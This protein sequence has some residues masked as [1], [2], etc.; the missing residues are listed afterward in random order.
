VLETIRTRLGFRTVRGLSER[1]V[2]RELFAAGLTAFDAIER[3]GANPNPSSLLARL[4]V[5]DLIQDVGLVERHAGVEAAFGKAIREIELAI[6]E[7]NYERTKDH[8]E[9]PL[10]PISDTSP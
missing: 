1:N 9:S 10:S 5:R 2:Y 7:G 6:T 8:D 4:E 3:P